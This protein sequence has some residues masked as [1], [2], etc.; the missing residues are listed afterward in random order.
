MRRVAFWVAAAFAV[1][2]MLPFPLGLVPG[3]GW[4]ATIVD[5]PLQ[6]GVDALASLL[7]LGPPSR[8]PTGSGDTL[9][10]HL[11]LLL[12]ALAALVAGSAWALAA[13]RRWEARVAAALRVWLRYW[14]AA[15]MLVYGLVKVLPVQ[16]DVPLDYIYDLRVGDKSPMGLLWLFMGYSRP[17]TIACGLVEVTAGCLLLWRR[18]ALAGALVA[19]VAM[20]QIVLLNFCYDVPVKLYSLELLA[21]ALA[22]AA[23]G[24]RRMLIAALG[25]AVP[26]LPPRV[27]GTPTFERVRLAAKLALLASFALALARWDVPRGDRQPSSELAG[28]WDVKTFVLDGADR[29]PLTTDA[30]RWAR[31]T[32]VREWLVVRFMPETRAFA[33]V[34]IDEAR[35]QLVILAGVRRETW[36]YARS[37]DALVL[38]GSLDGH[39]YH[40][41]LA[42]A[43]AP[44]LQT[45]GFHWIQEEPFHR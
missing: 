20:T 34:E 41:A 17:Y 8:V 6:W 5:T 2:V 23:P 45:R 21:A 10:H 14:L 27:R 38:D 13:P 43:P 12:V 19:I 18:T 22:I 39:R 30:A 44:L 28:A 29:L 7:G 16:F 4:L 37:A 32:F 26:E 3:T 25:R 24:M 15:A 42:R 33:R 11:R 40:V 1:L 35:K 31:V 9:Y 36:T